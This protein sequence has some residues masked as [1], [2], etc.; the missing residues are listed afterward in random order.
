MAGNMAVKTKSVKTVPIVVDVS[1][2]RLSLCTKSNLEPVVFAFTP[3]MISDLE[4]IN[5]EVLRTK[6]QDFVVQNKIKP[7]PLVIILEESVCFE[8]T[9]PGPEQPP[10]EEVQK[11]IDT[12]PF[13]AVSSKLFRVGN[14]FKLVAINRD[15][16]ETLQQVF[17]KLQFP[18]MSVVP[19]FVLTTINA[20]PQFSGESCRVIYRKLDVVTESSF[21]GGGAED[22]SFS[23]KEEA[24]LE[25]HKIMVVILV[26]AVVAGCIAVAIMTLTR[27]KPRPR[28]INLGPV[29]T[30]MV[31]MI[32]SPTPEAATYSAA[33]VQ[34]LSAQVLNGTAVHGM[35][36]SWEA[37]LRAWGIANITTGNGPATV[38]AAVTFSAK[39]PE[40][41]RKVMTDE[42]KKTWS[43]VNATESAS[44]GFDIVLVVGK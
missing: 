6:L 36:A 34:A 40:T 44:S 18:L 38:G 1:R 13:S 16:Y 11:F 7:T 2:E 20:P 5:K 28:V 29:P 3:E 17:E 27:K 42:L 24:W 4:V 25:K 8:K 21:S 22:E 30:V 12:V 43:T 41:F 23:N 32:A 39:V 33:Q 10:M 35:A 31:E 19:G 26:L 15:L 37:K 9:Y 14:G